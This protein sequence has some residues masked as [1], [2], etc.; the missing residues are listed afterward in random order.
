M[1][2]ATLPPHLG[3]GATLGRA[4]IRASS[5]LSDTPL[6]LPRSW[7]G[8]DSEAQGSPEH[9]LCVS[10]SPTWLQSHRAKQDG[11]KPWIFLC[12]L[13]LSTGSSHARGLRWLEVSNIAFLGQGLILLSSSPQVEVSL[14][15]P[16][17]CL[18]A[19]SHHLGYLPMGGVEPAWNLLD[20][21]GPVFCVLLGCA[22]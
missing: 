20:A 6:I 8:G 21:S 19:F 2:Q 1:D 15:C 12:E 10:V 4:S 17:A 9:W 5:Y 22:G 3:V 13:H 7:N 18:L 11:C 14:S 16:Q